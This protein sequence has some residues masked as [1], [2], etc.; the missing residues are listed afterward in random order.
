MFAN[1]KGGRLPRRDKSYVQIRFYGRKVLTIDHENYTLNGRKSRAYFRRSASMSVRPD[2]SALLIGDFELD[3]QLIH[4]LFIRLGWTLFEARGREEAIRCLETNLVHIVVLQNRLPDWDWKSAL[5][6]LRSC[7]TPAQ[8]IVASRHADET[9]WSEV[10]NQGGYDVLI[11]PFDCQEVERVL[12][13]AHRHRG[14]R[15][16]SG[17]VGT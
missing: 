11:Q 2:V 15:V 6:H 10:L 3:Q 14:D 12:T 7:T 5:Q 13:A 4:G 1:V 8:L 9:L 16:L 17:A